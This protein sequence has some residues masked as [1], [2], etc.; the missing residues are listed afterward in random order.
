MKTTNI[1]QIEHIIFMYQEY[2]LWY[3]II[4]NEKDVMDLKASKGVYMGG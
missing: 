4:I 3:T 1:N 2:M